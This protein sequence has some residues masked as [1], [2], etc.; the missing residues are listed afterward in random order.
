M[1]QANRI[2]SCENPVSTEKVVELNELLET[3]N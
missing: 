3:V 1:G 2:G